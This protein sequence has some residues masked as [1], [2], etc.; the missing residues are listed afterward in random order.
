LKSFTL[1]CKKYQNLKLAADLPKLNLPFR[2]HKNET[3]RALKSK[4]RS[5]RMARRFLVG[6]TAQHLFSPPKS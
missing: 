6:L 2:I 1:V 3:K 5:R 4:N